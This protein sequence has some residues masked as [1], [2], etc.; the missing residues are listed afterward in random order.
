MNGQDG[1]RKICQQ[2]GRSN[3]A[4]ALFCIG[5]GRPFAAENMP[6]GSFDEKRSRPIDPAAFQPDGLLGADCFGDVSAA[7]MTRLV[8]K[9]T[10][11]YLPVFER[12][13]H[14]KRAGRFHF[15]ALIF[16]GGW[17]L[18]RKQ[19][20]SGAVVLVL[21]IL[22]RAAS[23]VCGYL[24]SLPILR[25]IYAAAGVTSS[26][27]TI[28]QEQ[29]YEI[30]AG[31]MALPKEQILLCCS[32]LLFSLLGLVISVIVA[33]K[34]NR[35][36]FR[37]LKKLA[38]TVNGKNFAVREDRGA[39]LTRRGG[40]NLPLVICLLVCYFILNNYSDAILTAF[41]S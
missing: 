25:S 23:T 32:P 28:T 10:K 9:N 7:D 8:G 40:T 6:D 2:C 34:A 15:P 41:F 4:D 12:M 35:W 1:E 11:Y 5:C 18:Y 24:Y 38:D 30:T 14:S 33:V 13:S 16:G 26:Q 17:M 22:L 3:P 27:T 39:E 29:S 37:H 19:Y 20:F 21:Q 36:Y 31:F